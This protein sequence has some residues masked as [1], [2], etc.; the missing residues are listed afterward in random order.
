MKEADV[1]YVWRLYIIKKPIYNR[2][3][4]FYAKYEKHFKISIFKFV[5]KIED[6]WNFIK[7][8]LCW[9]TNKNI[10]FFHQNYVIFD[11]YNRIE[12]SNK[13]SHTEIQNKTSIKDVYQR[14]TQIYIIKN[15]IV[16]FYRSFLHF[17][18]CN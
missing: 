12:S 13:I 1:L 9:S 10:Y 8:K 18:K 6:Q 14:I 17:P 15:Y 2:N 7:K 3:V 16:Y 5:S 4:A 11:K